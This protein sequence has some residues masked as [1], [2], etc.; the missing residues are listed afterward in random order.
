VIDGEMKRNDNENW[1]YFVVE[2]SKLIAKDEVKFFDAIMDAGAAAKIQ[3][4][5]FPYHKYIK[6]EQMDR[7]NERLL[8]RIL[9]LNKEI[10]GKGNS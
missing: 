8:F 6:E 4:L 9:L 2:Q 10:E 3:G 7:F 5:E 1:E